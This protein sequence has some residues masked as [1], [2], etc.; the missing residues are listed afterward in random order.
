[1]G[2]ILDK[3]K[4]KVIADMQKVRTTDSLNFVMAIHPDDAEKLED[5]LEEEM[6]NFSIHPML[7]V[8]IRSFNILGA[9]IHAYRTQDVKKG[10]FVLTMATVNAVQ[11]I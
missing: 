4:N 2:I 3:I 10:Y 9:T 11:E 8:D 5:E 1:M 7:N 6:G